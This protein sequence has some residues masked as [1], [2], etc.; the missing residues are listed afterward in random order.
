[1]KRARR[2][3]GLTF[4]ITDALSFFRISDIMYFPDHWPSSEFQISYLAYFLDHQPSFLKKKRIIGLLQSFRYAFAE[5]SQTSWQT[6]DAMPTFQICFCIVL[7]QSFRYDA[8][9][10]SRSSCP[11]S[12]QLERS[13]GL[14]WAAPARAAGDGA[15]G[16]ERERRARER[17]CE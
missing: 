15:A 5:E 13:L 12:S 10:Y 6:P 4:G 2:L 7:L 14:H 8:V 9:A 1:M 11:S 16:R 17:E 3:T